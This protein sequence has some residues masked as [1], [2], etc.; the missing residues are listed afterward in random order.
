LHDI[1]HVA[2]QHHK[3]I[4]FDGFVEELLDGFPI[5]SSVI[6]MKVPEEQ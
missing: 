5:G 2:E 1:E 3:R 4:P 6:E